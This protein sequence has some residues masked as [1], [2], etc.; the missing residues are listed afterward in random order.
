MESAVSRVSNVGLGAEP[1]VGIRGIPPKAEGLFSSSRVRMVSIGGKGVKAFL[2]ISK[3]SEHLVENLH[4]FYCA[5]HCTDFS[6]LLRL[7]QHN[8]YSMY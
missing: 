5:L 6:L 1:V 7:P 3:K 8:Q 2:N 4:A